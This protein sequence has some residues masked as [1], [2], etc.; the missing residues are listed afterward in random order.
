MSPKNK[1]QLEILRIKAEIREIASQDTV[2]EDGQKKLSQ[3]K[4]ELRSQETK[5]EAALLTDGEN[6]GEV[7]ET[8]ALDAETRE[9]EELRGRCSLIRYI[10]SY[11]AGKSVSGAELE[12]RDLHG[13][14]DGQIPLALLEEPVTEPE[15]R[16]ITAAPTTTGRN[17]AAMIPAVFSDSVAGELMIEMPM[18]PSGSHNET[19]ITTN[20]STAWEGISDDATIT[21][22]AFTQLSTDSHRISG[23]LEIAQETLNAVGIPAFEASLR[24]NL[25]AV[26]SNALDRALLRGS[27]TGDEIS[28][29]ITNLTAPT[30]EST[31]DT[32]S[33]LLTK[34][35]NQIDGIW[36]RNLMEVGI[37]LNIEVVRWMVSV[38]PASTLTTATRESAYDY[39]KSRLSSLT[40]SAQMAAG[41][42]NVSTALVCKKG[43]PG[44]R[45]AVVP[46]WGYLEISDI[47]SLALKGQ[48][49][50]VAHIYV[51]DCLVLNPGA[52]S[53][54]SIKTA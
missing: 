40:S 5:L 13:F 12:F 7:I 26:M 10:R 11:R 46:H 16:A 1:I 36:A 33:S 47:Y 28:G 29:L 4:N 8:P 30:A 48:S 49:R 34:A 32:F 51:G 50:Y 41:A 19:R 45:R 23:G 53:L 17:M 43:K 14:E 21:A 25:S 9:R 44:N 20:L 37:L 31:T 22:A 6:S 42:S 38:W 35:S 24:Q 39:L 3:L 2:N 27:G 52:Y 15:T 18:V 54:L